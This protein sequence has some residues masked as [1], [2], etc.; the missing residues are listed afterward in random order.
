MVMKMN[1]IS[2]K[3]CQS[4]DIIKYGLYKDVQRYFCKDCK[5][6]FAGIDTIPKMQYATHKVSDAINMY[7]EGMS[8]REIRRNFIQQHND[9]ISD[10]SALNWVTRFSKLAIMEAGQGRGMTR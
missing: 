5:R 3:Y 4:E 2:C 9:Y 10:V 1:N 7:Y 8:L 6:K